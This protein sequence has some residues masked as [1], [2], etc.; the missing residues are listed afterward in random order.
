M[1]GKGKLKRSFT[2][3]DD[4]VDGVIVAS[5]LKRGNYIINLG[6]G[7]SI[8]VAHLVTLL[9][10]GLNKKAKR[11]SKPVPKGDVKE[12]NASQEMALKHLKFKPKVSFEE[13]VGKF[14][15]WFLEHKEFITTLD[16]PKQ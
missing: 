16:K 6:G 11:V 3:I 12:T 14:C 7:E 15:E 5:T 9:E 13:G 4:I 10:K 1:Y 8:E 2:Y